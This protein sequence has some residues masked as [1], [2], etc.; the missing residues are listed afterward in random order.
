MVFR[1]RNPDRLA[2]AHDTSSSS[3]SS[4]STPQLSLASSTHQDGLLFLPS[5]HLS[6]KKEGKEG[7][8]TELPRSSASPC[9]TWKLTRRSPRPYSGCPHK[10]K[11]TGDGTAYLCPRCNNAQVLFSFIWIDGD[12]RATKRHLLIPLSQF[13]ER[14]SIATGKWRCFCLSVSVWSY[15][16]VLN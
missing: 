8:P 10:I 16:K 7:A 6:S 11:Q 1:K 12:V 2:A 3:R 4:T 9:R 14:V 5:D 15:P 13:V